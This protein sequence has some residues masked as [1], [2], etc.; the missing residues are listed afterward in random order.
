MYKL[1]VLHS[2]VSPKYDGTLTTV[3]VSFF[4]WPGNSRIA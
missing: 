2:R 4:L 3:N 1:L